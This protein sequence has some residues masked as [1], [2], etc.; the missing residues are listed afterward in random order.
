LR[1]RLRANPVVAA[2]LVVAAIVAR[3]AS[4]TESATKGLAVFAKPSV[5]AK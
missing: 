5:A 2:L 1:G 3:V 4:F